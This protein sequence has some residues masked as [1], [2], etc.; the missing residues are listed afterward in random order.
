MRKVERQESLRPGTNSK[1]RGKHICFG[2]SEGNRHEMNSLTSNIFVRNGRE[3][4]SVRMFRSDRVPARAVAE[5]VREASRTLDSGKEGG[6]QQGIE[7]EVDEFAEH[8][9]CSLSVV[10]V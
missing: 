8:C 2:V 9:C 3:F 7:P 4:R 6:Y 10:A 5:S 1:I